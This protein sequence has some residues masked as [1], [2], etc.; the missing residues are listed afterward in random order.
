MSHKP[1]IRLHLISLACIAV[2]AGALVAS[3]EKAVAQS[4]AAAGASIFQSQCSVCHSDKPG[5]NGFGPTLAGAVGRKAAAIP[6]FAYTSAL[7]S[8][9]LV[10]DD[11]NLD[12]FLTDSA[13]KVA[14]TAM[15]VTIASAAARADL[16]AYLK[17]LGV[18]RAGGC[19]TDGRG[20]RKGHG[21]D[22]GGP[23][24][25]EAARLALRHT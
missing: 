5:V 6:G 2:A 10:W 1:S 3:G 19:G 8:S 12:Q 7:K 22:T 4:D 13:K 23:R 17:T 24:R 14:G 25:R 18:D 16:I 15:A 20:E 9:G 21:A 11:S